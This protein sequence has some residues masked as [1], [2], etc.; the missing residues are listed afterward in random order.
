MKVLLV[1]AE[2]QLGWELIRTC[3]NEVG[4]VAIDYPAI[5]ICQKENVSAQVE[6]I[7]PDWIINAAAY[8]AVDKAETEPEPA[9]QVNH[10][11]ARHLAEAAK[12]TPSRLVHVSTDFVFNGRNHKPYLPSDATDPQSVYGRTKRDG[13]LA[14]RNI[15][16]DE[17]LIVRTAWLYSSHGS[18]FV[19]TMLKLMQ[20]KD[21]LTVVDDQIGT[22]TWA[23]GLAEMIWTAIARD[24]NGTFHWTDD[25]SASWYDFALTIQQEALALGLLKK[26]IPILPIPTDQYPTPAKR[27]AYSVLDKQS[28]CQAT[29]LAPVHWQTQ[30]RAMLQ[31]LGE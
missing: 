3:P 12:T 6:A 24:L 21:R 11:G 4:L 17:A 30:L 7:A 15:L 20:E 16:Q 1:G 25:G 23:H 18:N 10:Q 28:T 31:E 8:T 5:D 27:P 9:D 29:G 14:V 26:E 13:E 22:P 19:K 2:G